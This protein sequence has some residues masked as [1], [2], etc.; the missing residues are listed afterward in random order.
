MRSRILEYKHKIKNCQNDII[1]SAYK[2]ELQALMAIVGDVEDDTLK[3]S[4]VKAM[5]QVKQSVYD[6]RANAPVSAVDWMKMG[7]LM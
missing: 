5:S 3:E 1:R 4:D 7:M 2:R 6:A